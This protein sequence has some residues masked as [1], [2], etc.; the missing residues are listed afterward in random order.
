MRGFFFS[1]RR[2]HT[3]FK[4]DWS[5]DVCSS[6]LVTATLAKCG[7]ASVTDDAARGGCTPLHPISA[8]SN[9]AANIGDFASLGLDSAYDQGA[10]S[11][12]FA[13]PGQNPAV[14]PLYMYHSG[15]RSVYNGMDLKFTQN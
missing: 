6:D 7:A 8:T 11:G 9:G 10:G 5:S 4:C 13:F 14:G 1:S 15:G 3:R 12:N 2:R